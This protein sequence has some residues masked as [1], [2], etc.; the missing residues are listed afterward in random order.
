MQNTSKPPGSLKALLSTVKLRPPS[1]DAS[2]WIERAEQA[3]DLKK[4]AKDQGDE[5]EANESWFIEQTCRAFCDYLNAWCAI[6]E[7]R[8]FDAW[9]LLEIAEITCGSLIR[10]PFCSLDETGVRALFEQIVEWQRIFPY[11]VFSSPELVVG[12]YEC[13]IC[14][15]KVDPWSSCPHEKGRVYLGEM[16]VNIAREVKIV[17]I[18]LVDDPVQKYSVIFPKKNADDPD[19]FDYGAVKFVAERL[20]GPFSRWTSELI[21]AR[22]PHSM[23]S[24]TPPDEPCPC[25]S[26]RSYR[27]CCLEKPGVLRPHVQISFSE[28]PPESLPSALF[29]DGSPGKLV[30][31]E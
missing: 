28:P 24:A 30:I 9:K 29:P 12:H 27:E 14:G 21:Q 17:G 15:L 18:S 13:S 3:L 8:F 19:P 26:G 7:L 6:K 5:V 25:E 4:I 23:F 1:D 16:C 2:V 11:K 10:N 22:H 20:S 31:R